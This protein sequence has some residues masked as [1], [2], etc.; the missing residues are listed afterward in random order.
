M[1]SLQGHLAK[2]S[3]LESVS[4][5]DAR[6]TKYTAP[7]PPAAAAAAEKYKEQQAANKHWWNLGSWL[8][9]SNWLWLIMLSVCA[10]AF[11]LIPLYHF[12]VNNKKGSSKKKHRG[13][14]QQMM[15]V[16]DA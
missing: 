4:T 3:N 8:G 13:L 11:C 15:Q 12:K 14:S 2:V 5:G 7:L 6:V 16:S 9:I 10:L 1:R